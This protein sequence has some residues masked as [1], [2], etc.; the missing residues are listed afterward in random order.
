M[1]GRGRSDQA[2]VA[3]YVAD[4]KYKSLVL[5]KGDFS[6]AKQYFKLYQPRGAHKPLTSDLVDTEFASLDLLCMID[7]EQVDVH[8]AE[9]DLQLVRYCAQE[10]LLFQG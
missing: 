10:E 1:T 7:S 9:E 2:L 8:E 3:V 6:I 5:C 4:S